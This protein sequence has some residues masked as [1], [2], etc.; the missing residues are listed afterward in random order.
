MDIALKHFTPPHVF[1]PNRVKSGEKLW[2]QDLW[3]T[4]K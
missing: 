1:D 2:D 4:T 3:N